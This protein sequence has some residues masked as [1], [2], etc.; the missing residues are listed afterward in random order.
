MGSLIQHWHLH[1][2]LPSYP[3]LAAHVYVTRWWVGGHLSACLQIAHA[4]PERVLS[5][6]KPSPHHCTQ[7]LPQHPYP[8]LFCVPGNLSSEETNLR[9]E[10]Y[11]SQ[12]SKLL[13]LSRFS[14]VRLCVTPWTAAHQAPLSLGLSR[15]EHWSGLPFP[16]PMQA[17]MLS[18]FS[19]VQLCVTL[20]TAALQAPLSR[21]FSRQEN[22]SGLVFPSPNSKLEVAY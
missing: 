5:F 19:R 2:L 9:K 16:S 6:T 4:K 22:W 10:F 18:R 12:N 14:R 15:Q 7:A 21:G 3:Q 13:L 11:S 8:H 17:C 1:P 20:W